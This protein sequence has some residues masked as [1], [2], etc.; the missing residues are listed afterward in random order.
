[1]A[2]LLI[3][4]LAI[5][6]GI[7]PLL[8]RWSDRALHLF[9]TFSCGIFLGAVFLHLLPEV[10]AA[11]AQTSHNLWLWVLAGLLGVYIL[12]AIF[13]RESHPTEKQQ[14]AMVSYAAFLGLGVHSLAEGVGLA[15]TAGNER[16]ALAVSLSVISH[17]AAG[18]FS[19]ATIFV[20]AELPRRRIAAL[21][22]VFALITPAAAL[23]G[24]V[25]MGGLS[26]EV[27]S[28]MTALAAGTFLFVVL[29]E[30]L[31]EVFHH[32]GE[33]FRKLGILVLGIGLMMVLHFAL[34]D[35]HGHGHGHGHGHDHSHPHVHD[36]SD[37][38][39]ISGGPDTEG[40][41]GR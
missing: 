29:C 18:A 37:S 41:A 26:G 9:I 33:L 36:P 3:F 2:S 21:M 19:L 22:V 1:M 38:E 27:S 34:E 4:L 10:G 17:K 5:V 32:H 39:P 7:L 24:D 25:V 14:H 8:T 35:S 12:E 6:G 20:L 13:M 28:I 16:L 31:P 30:L 15:A 40:A 23:G 11:T